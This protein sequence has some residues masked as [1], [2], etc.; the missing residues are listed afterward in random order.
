MAKVAI[1]APR[2]STCFFRW[3][4]RQSWK[5][6]DDLAGLADSV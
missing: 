4:S 5:Y 2:A 3:P 6:L 1:D